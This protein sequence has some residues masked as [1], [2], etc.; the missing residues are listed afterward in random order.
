MNAKLYL[1]GLLG[2]FLCSLLLWY[3][4]ANHL[5]ATLLK[6][7]PATQAELAWGLAALAA[8]VL[9][10]SGAAAAR[11]SGTGSRSGAAAS[12][13]VAGWLATLIVYILVSGAAAGL[14]GARPILAYGLKSASSEVQFLQLL[15]DSV[16][17]IHWWTMLALWGSLLAGLTLG[18]L[19]GFLAGPGG[20]PDPEM[21]LI[22]QVVGVSGVLTSGLVL[23]ITTLIL[24]LLSRATAKSVGQMGLT[25]AYAIDTLLIFP[26]VTLFLMMF[27]SLLLWWF[28]YRRGLAAGQEM[29]LQVRLSASVLLGA[30][31]VA[32]ILTFI[33]YHQPL[34]YGLYLP[35]FLAAILAGAGI[36]RHVW[37]NST[38]ARTNQLTTH[39]V[40]VSTALSFLVIGAGT[41][42]S[43]VPAALG[44]VM[45]VVTT[46]APLTPGGSGPASLTS[47]AQLVRDHYASYRNTGILL[48]L[49]ILPIFTLLISGLVGLTIHFASRY[50]RNRQTAAA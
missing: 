21:P 17:G 14:W 11:L 37:K 43:T 29:N 36:W 15:V 42:F 3:P 4:L 13:A 19:G 1:P 10:A 38:N 16:T 28:F 8:L 47:L 27:A 5:P 49:V 48:T 50:A 44:D 31:S 26:V 22:Y 6:D 46:I 18:A 32:L 34:F 24:D 25:P 33:V 30:P 41:Y 9:L 35:L 45:L 20:S 39:T 7:W 2:G 40:L 23:I 12:G